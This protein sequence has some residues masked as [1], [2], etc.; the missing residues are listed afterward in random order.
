[1]KEQETPGAHSG[2]H[3]NQS[4]TT[5]AISIALLGELQDR[6]DWEIARLLSRVNTMVGELLFFLKFIIYSLSLLSCI[7]YYIL[8]P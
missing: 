1:M 6:Q 4:G 8:Q 3:P 2:N 5:P 7:I